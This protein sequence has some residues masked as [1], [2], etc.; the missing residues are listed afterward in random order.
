MKFC[1]NL[2]GGLKNLAKLLDVQRIGPE[3]QAGSDSLLTSLTFIKLAN[4]FFAGVEGA[5]KHMGVLYGLGV[6]GADYRTPGD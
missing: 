3:H 2:H 5:S 1:N 6:D 4:R